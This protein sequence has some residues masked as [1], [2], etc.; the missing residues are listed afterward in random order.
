MLELPDERQKGD[1]DCGEA[2]V[3]CV[4]KYFNAS[5][6]KK[7]FATLQDGA[8][9]RQLEAALR[10]SGFN[11]LAGEMSVEELK[12]FIKTNRPVICLIKWE[13]DA[14]SHYAIVKGIEHKKV[15]IHD[16]QSGHVTVSLSKWQR[17]WL[18]TG[19]MNEVFK[20]WGIVAWPKEIE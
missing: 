5:I 19:R 18:A 13:N 20:R 2:A 9:P 10:L 11:V 15:F 17:M 4:L 14:E 6:A 1:H 16:V 3:A 12:H 8:D 7:K